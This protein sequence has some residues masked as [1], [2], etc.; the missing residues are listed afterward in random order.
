MASCTEVAGFLSSAF[1]KPM[2]ESGAFKAPIC[3]Y[4]VLNITNQPSKFNFLL[5]Q[6]LPSLDDYFNYQVLNMF[7]CFITKFGVDVSCFQVEIRT[8]CYH[9]SFY[10]PSGDILC[11]I[12]NHQSGGSS[13]CESLLP[14][15]LHILP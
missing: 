2:V 6:Q 10:I 5:Q 7:L 11:D 8:L 15:F 4:V 1:P 14:V 12:K 13:V 3:Y 9:C